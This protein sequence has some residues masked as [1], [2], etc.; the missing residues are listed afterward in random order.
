MHACGH[1]AHTAMLLGAAKVLA[2]NV[3]KIYG[4]VKLI[5][6]PGE[7]RT[8]GAKRMIEEGALENPHIDAIIGQH[9]GNIPIS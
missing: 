1:D 2:K 5:F 9:I 8:G 6:Q 3:D 4:N 7:E